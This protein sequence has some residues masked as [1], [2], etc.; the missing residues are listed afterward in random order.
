MH[1][2][3]T[4]LSLD[5][6]FLIFRELG[7]CTLYQHVLGIHSEDLTDASNLMNLFCKIPINAI[8]RY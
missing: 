1:E 5:V 3:I 8:Y 6:L 4:K 7:V 2:I